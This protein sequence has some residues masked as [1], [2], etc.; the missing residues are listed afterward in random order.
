MKVISTDNR[1]MNLTVL[2]V[3]TNED[4]RAGK[5]VIDPSELFRNAL[6]NLVKDSNAAMTQI[7]VEVTQFI[8]DYV[9][10]AAENE[11][12]DVY[13]NTSEIDRREDF[14]IY[15]VNRFQLQDKFQYPVKED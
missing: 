15:L 12:D 3:S 1:D 4:I 14:L 2:D 6:E 11:D 10:E 8:I 5:V 13:K 9:Q 7:A